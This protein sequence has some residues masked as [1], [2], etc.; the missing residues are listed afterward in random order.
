MIYEFYAETKNRLSIH[1]SYKD[2]QNL[3]DRS[4]LSIL[5]RVQLSAQA[6][7]SASKNTKIYAQTGEHPDRPAGLRKLI[8]DKKLD[9]YYLE[10]R[11]KFLTPLSLEPSRINLSSFPSGS[12]ALQ[13][14]FTLSKPYISR[15]DTDFYI[16]D[17]PVKKEWVFKVP[18]V[19]PSQW[20]GALR[21]AMMQELV[22][23]L[24]AHQIGEDTFTKERL[25]LWKLFGNEK[26]GASDFLNRSLV[27]HLMGAMPED[28]Q[29]KMDWETNFKLK[30]SEVEKE[31]EAILK[32]ERYRKGDIEGFHGSLYF[33]PSYFDRIALEVINPHDRVTGAGK[34]PIERSRYLPLY[35]GIDPTGDSELVGHL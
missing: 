14:A 18:Y 3:L 19:A 8:V 10:Q 35:C 24:N 23:K 30:I 12:W 2:I 27:R 28:E 25:R 13:L 4:D 7:A 22:G 34:N 1:A 9:E 5:A 29:G 21:S 26:D 17:N 20:K 15:D 16:L 32:D 33:Y 31:F 11:K 6:I